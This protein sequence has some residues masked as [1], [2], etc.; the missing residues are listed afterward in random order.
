MLPLAQ[1]HAEPP[2]PSGD[3]R[4]SRASRSQ[5]RLQ[6]QRRRQHG[7]RRRPRMPRIH[8]GRQQIISGRRLKTAGQLRL[9]RRFVPMH[10]TTLDIQ[11]GP[12]MS[13]RREPRCDG[14][15][16]KQ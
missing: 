15:H 10:G 12:M 1:K 13:A 9:G 5:P 6:R 16:Q 11:R 7:G 4:L 2:G 3:F 14:Q 8:T